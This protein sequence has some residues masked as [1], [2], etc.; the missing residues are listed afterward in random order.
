MSVIYHFDLLDSTKLIDLGMD[1]ILIYLVFC[2][3]VFCFLIVS[4]I[5]FYSELYNV[6]EATHVA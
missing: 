4:Y 6:L 1:L 2:S 5:F 3:F